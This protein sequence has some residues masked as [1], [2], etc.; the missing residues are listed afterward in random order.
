MTLLLN[1][2]SFVV[3]GV[4]IL[5]IV[6]LLAWGLLGPR[7]AQA[8]AAVTLGSLL[9]FQLMVSTKANEASSPQ[10]FENALASGKPVLL[11]LYS[12]F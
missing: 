1:S 5:I 7:W 12:N 4:M 11:E 9:I 8:I 3:F 6:T 2:Y 10:D